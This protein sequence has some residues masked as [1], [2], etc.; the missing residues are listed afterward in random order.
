MEFMH[1][2]DGILSVPVWATLNVAAIPCVGLAVRRA[3]Q[4]LSDGQVPLLG[5]MGAFVFAAQ[6]MNFPVGFGTSGHPRR[7]ASTKAS[8]SLL[9][10]PGT[11]WMRSRSLSMHSSPSN[12]RS[13]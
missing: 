4:Y 7:D 1:I 13:W 5:V 8:Q 9:T 10:A 6:R 2:P 12:W 3:K 11:R